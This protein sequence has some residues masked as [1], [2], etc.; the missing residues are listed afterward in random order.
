[1]IFDADMRL[2]AQSFW[3]VLVFALNAILFVLVGLQFPEILRRVGET[4]S[5]GEIIGYGLL[6][7][8][9]VVVVRVAWQFLPVGIGR[10][11]PA[12]GDTGGGEDWRERLLIGWTGMRGAVSLAAALALPFTL[13]SG[14]TFDSRDLIV[15]LTVAVIF[16]TLVGPGLDAAVAGQ[17][18]S[19]SVATSPGPRTRRWR[20]W[21]PR[22]R[23]W[24][25]GRARIRRHAHP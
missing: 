13:D 9:V 6:V 24:T 3:R 21:P 2:N 19:A 14:A 22:R 8:G 4:F 18:G 23:R 17:A 16:V 25:A 1:M 12:I 7:S 11:L 10:L 20:G 15:Y 5:P